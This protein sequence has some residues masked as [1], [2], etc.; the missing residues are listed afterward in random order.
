MSGRV[1]VQLLAQQLSARDLD[2]LAG[3]REF[4]LM[5]GEQLRRL[6]FP[7]DQLV[8]EARKMR[9]AMSR[10]TTLR[11]VVRLG[12]RVGGIHAGSEGHVYGLS[13]WGH[14]VLDLGDQVPGRHRRVIDTKP[15]FQWHVLA[16]GQLAVELYE[17]ERAGAVA[18]EE[19]KAEPGAWR[20]FS[21]IG[22][23]RRVLKPDAYLRV[24]VGDFLLSAFIEMD[25]A[26]E[27]LPTI[28]RKLSVYIDYWR[29][30]QEQQ[31][32][33]VFP[34]VWWLVPSDARLDAIA[35]TIRRLPADVHTLFTV[36]LARD[37]AQLLSQLNPQGGAR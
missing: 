4:R 12:R 16:V 31:Q 25:M 32:H 11:V 30:G 34:L 35:R 33:G 27:S 19:L 37:A 36:A 20:W 15:A 5:T 23:A 13:G 8:T 14:A 29:S 7:G 1:R 18:I 21:G 26:T 28:A 22:G 9:A 17:Q 2:I 24:G 10:L 3:L 6:H